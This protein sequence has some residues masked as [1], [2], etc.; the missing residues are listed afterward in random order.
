MKQHYK[1]LRHEGAAAGTGT[2]DRYLL[3]L[4]PRITKIPTKS[5]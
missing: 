3:I 1:L 4:K 2:R 5:T